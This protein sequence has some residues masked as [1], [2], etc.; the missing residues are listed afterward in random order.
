P[1]GLSAGPALAGLPPEVRRASAR[2]RARRAAARMALP[3]PDALLARRRASRDRG[4][5]VGLARRRVGRACSALALLSALRDELRRTRG[6]G[7]G[8]RRAALDACRRRLHAFRRHAR[9]AGADDGAL[10]ARPDLALPGLAGL[11]P[12]GPR[13]AAVDD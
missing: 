3:R 4:R 5:R 6:A 11:S 8:G 13:A 9:L 1:R 10:A 7:L 2:D 12:P